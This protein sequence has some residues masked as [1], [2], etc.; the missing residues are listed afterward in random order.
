MKSKD[1][2]KKHAK[3]SLKGIV[4]SLASIIIVLNIIVAYAYFFQKDEVYAKETNTNVQNVKIS[5]A[6]ALNV[7]EIMNKNAEE[8]Q[9]DEYYVEETELEYITKYQQNEQL[10]TGVMQVIQEGRN[11]KQEITTKR[12]YKNGEVVLEEQISSKITKASINKIVEVGS[13]KGRS[14]YKVKVGDTVYVT[15][16]RASVMTE[17]SEEAQKIATLTKGMDV[18][19]VVIENGWYKISG[20]GVDGY[21]KGENTT[22]INPNAKYEGNINNN[23][24]NKNNIQ[25]LRFDMAL[26]KPSGLSLEQFKKVLTD[27]KDKNNIFK[28]NAQYFY[29]IEQ[30]YNINGLFVAA[31]GIHESN[32]GTSKIAQ[33]KHNLFGYGAYDSNPYNGAYQF[34][35]YSE[36][37][38]LIARVFVKYYLNPKGTSIYGGEKAAGT[39]YN[40]PTLSGIN[41]KYATDKNW[42]NGVYKHMQYLYNKL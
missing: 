40:G 37:I 39:Y 24:E 41:K 13:G 8:A 32:W 29:Y 26:N 36:S 21:I 5:N 35:N 33:N 38:D 22:Y 20:Q 18:K 30:Q 10:P 25:S 15:S 1:K 28:N 12:S 3:V 9:Q 19:I 42:A 11:G 17:P 6:S 16:D 34:T 23:L 2:I 4:V 7:E 31:V 27:S 14:T